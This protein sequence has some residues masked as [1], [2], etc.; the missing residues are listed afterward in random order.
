[1][2][3]IKYAQNN[4]GFIGVNNTIPWHSSQDL[5]D[6]RKATLHNVIVM[7]RKTFESLGN[8]PLKNRVNFIVSL[9]DNFIEKINSKYENKDVYAFDNLETAIS[10]ENIFF[11]RHPEYSDKDIYIIGG[12]MLIE[13]AIRRLK[14]R[15]SKIEVSVINDETLGDT[16]VS[17]ELL[18]NCGIPVITKG[19]E[20]D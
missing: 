15:I 10:H 17:D 2:I 20:C 1:M 11:K 18:M 6:F 5:K 14:N 7:G 3:I 16:F 4:L 8:K 19:Y 12:A 13:S 9:N